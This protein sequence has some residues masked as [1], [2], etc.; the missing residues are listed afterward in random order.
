[1]GQKLMR[2]NKALSL[3]TVVLIFSGLMLPPLQVLPGMPKF[4]TSEILLPLIVAVIVPFRLGAISTIKF[5]GILQFALMGVMV[6]SMACNNRLDKIRDWFELLEVIKYLVILIFLTQFIHLIKEK[7]V[8]RSVFLCLVIF[9]IIHYFDL[10]QFNSIIETY[11]GS[12]IQ[13]NTF[14]VNSLGQPDT[15]RLLGTLGNPNNNAILFLFFTIYFFPK[16][17]EEKINSLFFI[18]AA[19][20]LLMCQSR[21]TTVAFMVL[22]IAGV[23]IRK[24]SIGQV[25]LF[26]SFF[27]FIYGLLWKGGNTYLSTI[28]N[29]PAKETSIRGR[30]ETFKYLGKM[31]C[32]SP[33]SGHSANKEFFDKQQLNADNEYILYAWRY[34]ILG[35][36]IY[37]VWLGRLTLLGFN[38][39]F[40]S[41]GFR[42]L[43]FTV[44]IG[45]SALTN[46]PL[47]NP[48]LLFLLIIF[49]GM[50]FNRL[51]EKSPA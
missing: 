23:L 30:M 9:N 38:A 50:Y 46:S 22:F 34:G 20:L 27:I 14:G 33:F 25:L 11:Y 51:I 40:T 2:H 18:S 29:N 17:N 19:T 13:V 35:L 49:V 37:L 10:F 1:M 6:F 4:H 26:L 42:L 8:F 39:R 7:F 48:Y 44:G 5:E 16:R 36:A 47:N 31:I 24:L 28:K 12:E 45:I 41:E 3:L 15:K 21:T 43:L 32:D